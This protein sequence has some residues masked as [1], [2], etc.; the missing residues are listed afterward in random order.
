[1]R[2]ATCLGK[3]GRRCGDPRRG[4]MCHSTLGRVSVERACCTEEV[5]RARVRHRQQA[6]RR[7]GRARRLLVRSEA[8][9]AHRFSRAQ[10]RGKT[11]AMRAVFGLVALDGGAVRWQ[12]A[13]IGPS[14]G[15]GSGTCRRSV[16]SIRACVSAT[17]SSTWVEL[18]G[19]SAVRRRAQRRHVAR[20]TGLGDPG[21]GPGRHLVARQPA[22]GA[23]DRRAG[24]RARAARARRTVLRSRP[25]RHRRHVRA[26]RRGRRRRRHRVVL[27]PPARP[28][29]GHLR[30]RRHHRRGTDRPIRRP[31]RSAGRGAAAI[32][33]PSATGA[34][35]PTGRGSGSVE[36]VDASEGE[37]RL[38]RRATASTSRR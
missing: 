36:L 23:A 17:S 32:R 33:R 29:R 2:P 31:H 19:R 3:R 9:A 34:P 15:R 28:G 18:C 37:A 5:G 16:A 13:E 11:T 22:A 10:R 4:P 20:P 38:R 25:D 14:S 35:L 1:M 6:F 12:G 30:G 26:A 21:E 8:G 27:E 7:V 24:Q